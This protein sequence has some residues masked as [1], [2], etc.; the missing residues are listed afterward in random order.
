MK[1]LGVALCALLLSGC[2]STE[3]AHFKAQGPAQ[4]AIVRD[5][6]N[7]IVSKRKNSIV[8]VSPATRQFSAS[9][10]PVYVVAITNLSRA[11]LD[12]H[13]SDVSVTQ[14]QDGVAVATLP[15]ITYEQLVS[16]ERSRQVARAILV[17]LVAG[18]NASA[19]A[20]AGYGHTYGT[21]VT[22]R[23]HVGTFSARTY[24]PAAAAYAQA[25]AAVE[26]AAMVD[27]A[28]EAG[29]QNLAALE[30]QVIKDNTLM[31]G[32]WYG[33]QLHFAPPQQTEGKP[34]TYTIT[35]RVGDDIHEIDVEQGTPAK[36][37]S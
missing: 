1:L 25:N 29:R 2:V 31:P 26:N 17:G 8:L 22:P 24:N 32:E 28:V 23:G 36:A 33:G 13:V 12:F 34:K 14:T 11:P 37:S 4:Q 10:R 35:I 15:V 19:A 7:A 5:G 20:N 18:A 3:V 21:Y 16:E 9:E 6:R 27:G 30:Q